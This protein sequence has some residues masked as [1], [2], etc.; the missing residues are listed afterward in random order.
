MK[1]KKEK[2]SLTK[3]GQAF[4]M[5]L[6]ILTA[7]QEG[8]C[9][10]IKV[11]CCMYIP[12]VSG[13]LSTALEDMQNQ[14]KVMSNENT[15]FWTSVLSWVKGDCN[16][17]HTAL[18]ALLPTMPCEFCN[19]EVDSILSL[20]LF[21]SLLWISNIPLYL[22]ILLCLCVHRSIVNH[23]SPK[24]NEI[25]RATNSTWFAEDLPSSATLSPTSWAT[26]L[27]WVAISFSRGSSQRA[28]QPTPVLLPGESHGQ[29]SLVG[30]KSSRQRERK[31]S[32]VAGLSKNTEEARM[33][34]LDFFSL[35]CEHGPLE[36]EGRM[37]KRAQSLVSCIQPG[38]VICF[39]LDNIHVSML[40]SQNIPLLPAPTESKSL[41]CTSI[42]LP[43]SGST[44]GLIEGK[45]SSIHGISQAR[46]RERGSNPCLLHWQVVSCIEQTQ[47]GKSGTDVTENETMKESSL[48]GKR[49]YRYERIQCGGRVWVKCIQSENGDW[50]T[51]RE[52]E[53]RGGHER[54]KNWKLSVRC[55]GRP[56]RWLMEKR[57]L[58]NPPRKYYGGRKKR[59]LKSHNNTL[60]DLCLGNSD[61]CETC[62]DG[63]KLFC[64]DT[65]SRSFHEDCHI[66]PVETEKSPW[67]CT[68]CRTTE[69]SGNQQGL[70]ESEVLARPMQPEEQLKCEFLLLK[71]YCHSESS[72]FSKIPYYYYI[73]EASKNL[74]E[75]MWLDKIKKRL[76]EQGYSHVEGFVQ[77]MRLIFQNHRASYKFHDFGRMGLRLEAEFEKNFKEVFA[78]QETNE[79]SCLE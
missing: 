36:E 79:D 11:E 42:I 70:K 55:G 43:T 68:F 22:Y 64:C 5:A 65:C 63:G 38:L 25:F 21:H 8:T 66:P 29:R 52:F 39:T 77:D 75:P 2:G 71:V 27:E 16:L 37:R 28:W 73:K 41:F 50:F 7:A 34:C 40:F 74:K 31:S 59:G 15:P 19:P 20:S 78:L 17:N 12:D 56:L 76:N 48:S 46:I 51:P 62:R 26:T 1:N 67:S 53:I 54:S 35:V 44:L 9:A 49:R 32:T 10:I 4:W 57:L 69:S 45:S 14:V 60:D 58:H 24:C 13:N 33:R 3:G 18:W 61:E 30:Y 23:I 47:H 72:F 6:D